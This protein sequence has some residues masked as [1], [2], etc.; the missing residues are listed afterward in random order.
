MFAGAQLG[1]DVTVATPP[2]FEPCVAALT[3]AQQ[4]ASQNSSTCRLTNDP[5]E[6]VRNADVVYTDVWASMGRET[7]TEERKKQFRDY[8]VNEAL[9]GLACPD[10]IF[11]HCLPAHRGDEVTDAVIDSARSV[12]FQQAEN[13]LHAQKAVLLQLMKDV[14]LEPV[15]SMVQQSTGDLVR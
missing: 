3:W 1:A 15:H 10:A 2:G 11:M 4:R 14:S 9:F 5:A 7:E 12:V 6:A 8:Q 13:R